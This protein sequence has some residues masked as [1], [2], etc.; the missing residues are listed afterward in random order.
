M[1]LPH[2]FLPRSKGH[3]NTQSTNPLFLQILENTLWAVTDIACDTFH[4]QFQSG[5]T[6]L[7]SG[8]HEALWHLYHFPASFQALQF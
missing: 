1:K 5:V 4:R 2:Y 8:N 6:L 3:L 7:L